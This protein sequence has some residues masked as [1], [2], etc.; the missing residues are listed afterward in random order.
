[1]ASK[2]II[3]CLLALK[4]NIFQI[5]DPLPPIDH[6]TIEYDSFEKNFYQEHD[7]I[8]TLTNPQAEELRQILGIKVSGFAAPKPVSSFAHF[9]FDEQLMKAIRKSEFTQPTPIQGNEI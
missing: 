4:I 6:S 9:N 2:L 3:L 7:D 8:K 5:I 1:M